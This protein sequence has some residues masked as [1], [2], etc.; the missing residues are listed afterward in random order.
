MA[1]TQTA[2]KTGRKLRYLALWIVKGGIISLFVLG[3]LKAFGLKQWGLACFLVGRIVSWPHTVTGRHVP[4]HAEKVWGVDSE[5]SPPRTSFRRTFGF[6][7]MSNICDSYTGPCSP[8]FSWMSEH[9]DFSLEIILSYRSW[10][11]VNFMPEY[12]LN[13]YY[14]LQI[15]MILDFINTSYLSLILKE[16]I[17][18]L[19]IFKRVSKWPQYTWLLTYL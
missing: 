13:F 6:F 3:V 8:G 4:L 1:V 14:I 15:E 2:R 9:L 17:L 10:E 16:C 19:W 5:G 11:A 18:V 7:W 12:A